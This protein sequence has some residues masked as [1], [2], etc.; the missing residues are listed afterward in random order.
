MGVLNFFLKIIKIFHKPPINDKSQMNEQKINWEKLNVQFFYFRRKIT[1]S[2]ITTGNAPM[3]SKNES[4]S[5]EGFILERK[6]E[7]NEISRRSDVMPRSRH[8]GALVGI[9]TEAPAIQT[10]ILNH[11]KD[12]HGFTLVSIL[13][14][15]IVGILPLSILVLLLLLLNRRLGSNL[16]VGW[17][18]IFHNFFEFNIIIFY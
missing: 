15:G 5:A 9:T 14:I 11:L 10:R 7:D 6:Y 17:H 1:T 3:R 8:R 18:V 16:L 13:G 12:N 2:D 4:F